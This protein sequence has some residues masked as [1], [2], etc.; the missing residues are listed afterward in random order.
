MVRA[1]TPNQAVGDREKRLLSAG[2]QALSSDVPR[3][4]ARRK[5]KR[6]LTPDLKQEGQDFESEARGQGKNCGVCEDSS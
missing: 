3:S 4:T 2:K 6:L 5:M 1:D